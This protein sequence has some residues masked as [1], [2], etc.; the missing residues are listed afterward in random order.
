MA[1]ATPS[2]RHFPT[3]SADCTISSL[4]S[5]AP[6]RNK[7]I[8]AIILTCRRRRRRR[9]KAIGSLG[10]GVPYTDV[11]DRLTHNLPIVQPATAQCAIVVHCALPHCQ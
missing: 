6:A 3:A 9:R 4:T 2:G 11:F 10:A 1:R 7:Q 8:M 5:K